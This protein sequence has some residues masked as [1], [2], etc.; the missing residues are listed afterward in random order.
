MSGISTHILDISLGRP[1]SGVSVTLDLSNGS[2]WQE[3]SSFITDEDGRVK[4]L[5]PSGCGLEAGSY[6][7]SFHTE[8]YFAARQVEGLYPVIQVNFFVRDATAHYHIPL[9][10]TAN[11]Y[12]TYRGN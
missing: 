11:G 4:Q 5:L 7:I 10:L 3:L 9:L 12:S 8:T 2:V 1:A 6:R